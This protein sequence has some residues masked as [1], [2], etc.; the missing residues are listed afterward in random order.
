MELAPELGNYSVGVMRCFGGFQLNGAGAPTILRDMTNAASAKKRFTVVRTSIGLYTVTMQPAGVY[1]KY[2]V[3]VR[4]FVDAWI[5]QAAVPTN[6]C[7]A[8]YVRNSWNPATRTF[9]IAVNL[10][11]TNAASDGD[12]ADR[13][14]FEFAGSITGPGTDP[15]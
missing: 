4:P 14:S 12:A 8:H 11:T 6:G 15:A 2:P 10:M 1:D 7:S 5:E 9:Q 13:I 3:P